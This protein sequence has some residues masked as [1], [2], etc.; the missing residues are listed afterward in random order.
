MPNFGKDLFIENIYDI[1][2]L[3]NNLIA[4][5]NPFRSGKEH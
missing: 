5:M 3:F 4:K 2:M 1:N